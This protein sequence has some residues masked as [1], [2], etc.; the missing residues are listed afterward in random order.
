MPDS[1]RQRRIIDCKAAKGDL[2]KETAM[3]LALII[4]ELLMNAVKYAATSMGKSLSQSLEPAPG[5]YELC[6]Q[7]E[8]FGSIWRTPKSLVVSRIG[9][10]RSRNGSVELQCGANSGRALHS[11]IP[12]SVTCRLVADH[13]RPVASQKG[14][15]RLW[16]MR[17]SRASNPS[18]ATAERD[19]HHYLARRGGSIYAW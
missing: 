11:K 7:D 16:T 4:N 2:P 9:Q 6:V 17:R 12:R 10:G 15:S 8:G 18:S 14:E 5:L 1:V 19:A 13:A 3:P